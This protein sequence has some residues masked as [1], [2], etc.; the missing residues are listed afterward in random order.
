MSVKFEVHSTAK[1]AVLIIL[2]ALVL[3]GTLIGARKLVSSAQPVAQ[4]SAPQSIPALASAA[5]YIA[6]VIALRVDD[7]SREVAWSAAL[8][9]VLNGKTEIPV[10]NGR[11]DV[12]TDSYAIEVDRF[13]KWHEGVGQAAHYGLATGKIPCLALII[14]SDRWPLNEFTIG[15]LRTIEQT[16]L[17]KGVKLLIL[18]R[19]QPEA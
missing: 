6:P 7:A 5:L 8:A 15:K 16:A 10:P 12:L 11:V 17:S 1:R 2:F 4:L 18:R 3:S 9:A 13:D 19:V 14:E